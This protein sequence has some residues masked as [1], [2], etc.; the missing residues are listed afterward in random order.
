M[1]TIKET[2]KCQLYIYEGLLGLQQQKI[3]EA[4][5]MNLTWDELDHI[6]R[7]KY[8]NRTVSIGF[9]ISRIFCVVFAYYN[10]PYYKD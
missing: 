10:N 4:V 5:D 3:L 9:G 1:K 8:G 7:K 6:I 2:S